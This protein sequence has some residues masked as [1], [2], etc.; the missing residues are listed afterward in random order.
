MN[1]PLR[2]LLAVIVLAFAAAGLYYAWFAPT[3][4]KPMTEKLDVR[5]QF[6]AKVATD[7]GKP[8]EDVRSSNSS[9]PSAPVSV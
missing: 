4:N 2:A 9:S 8:M 6:G 1:K 5:K 3:V 7:E